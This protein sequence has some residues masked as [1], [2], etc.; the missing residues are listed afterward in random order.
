MCS[1]DDDGIDGKNVPSISSRRFVAHQDIG[2]AIQ[3]QH[4]AVDLER[5]QPRYIRNRCA[6]TGATARDAR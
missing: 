5:K 4:Q 6:Q 1:F 2:A 3:L